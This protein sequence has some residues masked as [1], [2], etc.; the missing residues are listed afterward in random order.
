MSRAALIEVTFGIPLISRRV[1]RNWLS[2]EN[3]LALRDAGQARDQKWL[4]RTNAPLVLIIPQTDGRLQGGNAEANGSTHVP[5]WHTAKDRYGNAPSKPAEWID[6]VEGV[7]MVRPCLFG[8][9]HSD[10]NPP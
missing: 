8:I 10:A 5:A 2:I 1:A 7:G 9:R 6:A 4:T 3:L